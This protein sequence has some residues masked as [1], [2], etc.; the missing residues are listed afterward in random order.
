MASSGRQCGPHR[1]SADDILAQVSTDDLVAYLETTDITTEEIL[2]EIDITNIDFDFYN[3]QILI[4]DMEMDD[5]SI[6][7]LYDEFGLESE[8]L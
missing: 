8:I 4:Q 7:F 2:E 5:E 1:Q 6:D 3:D